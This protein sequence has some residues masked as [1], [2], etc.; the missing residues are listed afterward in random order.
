M[1][2]K[3]KEINSLNNEYIKYLFKLKEKKFRNQE[4]KFIIEGYH[5][6]NEAY[7]ANVLKEILVTNE[8]NEYND[9]PK[10]KVTEPIINKL[11]T[12]VNP[13]NIL[14][15]CEIKDNK[16]I[17]G[18]KILLLDNINDPGNLG[19]LIRSS[20]GFNIS[21]IVLSPDCVD[22]YNEKVIRATQ[23]GIFK[24]NIIIDDL[25]KVIKKLQDNNIKVFGTSLE[26]SKFLQEFKTVNKYAIL[27]G[28]EANG[29]KDKLLK[30]T[31]ENIKI[32]INEQLESLNVA[33]AGSI[34]MYYFD[35]L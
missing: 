8:I 5:L 26:S 27:L 12:T 31:D 2:H 9:I 22:L 35:N 14:G 24:V 16:E 28:N 23:G 15:I 29:V 19:T 6:V 3:M 17:T 10:I 7:K 21:T 25:E 33:V 32:E 11:S 1:V 4:K 13:Q 34:I 30:L 20:L 18:N